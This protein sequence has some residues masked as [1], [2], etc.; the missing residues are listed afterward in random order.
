[1]MNLE[2]SHLFLKRHI[3]PSPEDI[4]SM[5]EV[6]GEKSLDDFVKKIIPTHIYSPLPESKQEK[7]LAE[8]DAL[9]KL[10]E[11]SEK[12]ELYRNY[13]GCGYYPCRIPSVLLRNILENPGWY[14]PYTPYQP[15]IS[16]GRL[17]SLF[18]FQTMVTDLTGLPIAGASLLDEAT[19]AME[20]VSLSKSMNREKS[21]TYFASDACHPQ[22]LAVLETRCEALG[23]ELVI[24]KDSEVFREEKLIGALFQYPNT[25]GKVDSFKKEI[26]HVKKAGGLTTLSCDLLSL[27]LL[28][29]P[30]SLGADIAVGSAQRFGCSLSYGGPHAGFLSTKETFKRKVPGRIVGLSKDRSGKPAYRL[31]LQTREQHI[32]RESATSNICTAQALLANISAMYAVHH[33]PKGL[34]EQAQSI[35]L[36]TLTLAKALQ[37]QG[38]TLKSETFFDT[39]CLELDSDSYQRIKER[40]LSEKINLRYDKAPRVLL[41]CDETCTWDD[42]KTL[43]NVFC[44]GETL[45]ELSWA[46]PLSMIPRELQRTT[47]YLTHKVFNSYQSET[48]LMRYIKSLENKDLSLVHSMIPLGSCTMKLNAACEMLPLT[49][50]AFAHMHPMAP[51]EQTRGYQELMEQLA[52]TLKNLTG[53]S[54]ISFQPNSG[55]QGELTGLLVIKKYLESKGEGERNICLIPSSAHGTN[56]ASAVLSGLK[57]VTVKCNEKGGLDYDDLQAKLEI[58][59]GKIAALMITYPSTY[60]IFEEEVSTCCKMI[61]K[62]GGQ[63]YL[64]GANFNAKL[65]LTTAEAIGADVCHLNLHKTFCIPHGGGGPGAGPIAVR[66]HLTPFLP[67]HPG[68]EKVSHEKALKA[69]AASEFSSANLYVIPWMYCQ[70]MGSQGL[71][72]SSKVAILNANYL[73]KKLEGHYKLSFR[74]HSGFIAHECILDI[75]P[76]TEATGVTVHDMAKRLMDYGF[77]APTVSWPV[78]GSLMIEPTE[79]ESRE[80]LDRFADALISIRQEIQ[81]VGEGK[82]SR[83]NN[84]LTGAPHTIED[85]SSDNWERPYTRQEA[86]YPAGKKSKKVFWPSVSRIDEAF[87]DRQFCCTLG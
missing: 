52:F 33:G 65:G 61:H 29:S 54:E 37:K 22:T 15:E 41:S 42:I 3:G 27:A 50:P 79:S 6:L 80:E 9:N 11:I 25:Y 62:E 5:L 78:V 66:S 56:P 77:H 2:E 82:W 59:Q 4:Q 64:D 67:T 23:V 39:L 24:G 47:P 86:A 40:A 71:A 36:K 81:Q 35:H 21:K 57:V 28:E 34:K 76:L 55:A 8:H 74:G 43:F 49:W 58:H 19:A 46:D 10:K 12:N 60:G 87:G 38:Y 45:K 1:M 17:E 18:N 7:P 75:N 63:V 31:A 13:I 44:P 51:L 30:G 70:T 20:A 68:S 83:E 84:P 32:R 53:F 73:M 85:I 69:V 72:L 14:T 26:E 48:E 16:Q